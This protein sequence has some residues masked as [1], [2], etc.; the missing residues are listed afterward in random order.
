MKKI[1]LIILLFCAGFINAQD[2]NYKIKNISENTKLADFGVTYYGENE[3]V[4]ASS[5]K[6]KSI[7]SRKWFGNKQPY[8]ELFKGTL[9]ADGEIND[10]ERFSETINTKYHESN[11]TFTKDLKTVYFSRNNYLNKKVKKDDNDEI[12]IQM[13]KATVGED[14][15]W[16]NIT[17]MPFNSDQYQTGHPSLNAKENKLY[18][19]SDMPGSIGAEDIYVVDINSDGTYGEPVNLGPNVNTVR[20]E[21]FPFIDENNVLYFSSNGYRDG[22]GQLDVYATKIIGKEGIEPAKNLG[23]PINSKGD[24]FAF[25]KKSGANWG[26]FSSNREFGKGDDDIY[27]FEEIAPDELDC[28]QFVE[29]VVREKETGALLPGALVVLYGEDGEKIESVIAD[30]FASFS[31][32]VDCKTPYKIVGTKQNYDMDSEEFETSDVRD[33]ELALGLT[34]APSE[35][36]VVRGK[37][38]VNINPIYFD[39]DKSFIRKDAAIELDKVLRVMK[40]YPNIKIASGSHT[41]SRATDSYNI[42]LSERR[43]KSSVEWII[44]R[45][46]DPSRITGKGYGETQL[47][48]KCSDGVKCSE[49][50]HQLNRRTEFIIVN[51]EAIQQ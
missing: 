3:A 39:L 21:M 24:D 37:L 5:R 20:E 8:L 7:R 30:K 6:D 29:G 46:I 10:V 32:I 17:P 23:Y 9:G 19:T 44:S 34:L 18:F 31:F 16:T 36:I 33:L 42:K 14:G 48:N 13:Y 26:H 43:A 15:E 35:F 2:V 51:P 40:K 4:F 38:M 1:T 27:Y 22:E 47:V 28:N 25:V 11:V 50:E 49:A 41:D 45:G 12:L